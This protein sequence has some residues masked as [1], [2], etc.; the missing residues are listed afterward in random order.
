MN[1]KK[2][3]L[4][5]TLAALASITLGVV[6][7][8]GI[9]DPHP[10]FGALGEVYVSS[11]GLYYKTFVSTTNITYTGH[12]GNSFQL[13]EGGATEFGP[14]DPGYRGGRWWIDDGD[15]IIGMED[16]FVLCPLIG[17]GY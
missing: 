13:L 11:Q 6:T 9:V 5:L 8:K 1:P 16:T 12:N 3:V 7:V 10:H 2:A 14:G 17:P 15:G 4:L